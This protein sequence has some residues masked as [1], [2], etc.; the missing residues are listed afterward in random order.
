MN[1]G[2]SEVKRGMEVAMKLRP[3]FESVVKN[4]EEISGEM[5]NLGERVDG[6]SKGSRNIV[7]SIEQLQKIGRSTVKHIKDISQATSQH[8]HA[9]M[10]ITS[11]SRSLAELAQNLQEM[12]VKF[13]M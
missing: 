13:S 8:Q 1:E 10:D 11:A 3:S 2:T 12:T 4:I 6:V 9:Q 7:E 5:I